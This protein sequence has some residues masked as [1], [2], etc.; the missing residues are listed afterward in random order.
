MVCIRRIHGT[1]RIGLSI[2][3]SAGEMGRD[4]SNWYV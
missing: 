2:L 4:R 3:F 1:E